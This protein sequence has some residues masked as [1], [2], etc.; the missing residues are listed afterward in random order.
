M[1]FIARV[2]TAPTTD[3]NRRSLQRLCLCDEF[4]A[5]DF[6]LV[7]VTNEVWN[8]IVENRHCRRLLQAWQRPPEGEWTP[9]GPD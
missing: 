5:V 6:L 9:S 2:P 1:K 7:I 4:G 3:K 8:S